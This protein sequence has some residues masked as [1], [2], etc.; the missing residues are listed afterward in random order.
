MPIKILRLLVALVLAL[1]IPLQGAASV[2]AGICMATGHHDAGAP[3]SHDHGADATSHDHGVDAAD[4]HSAPHD[5][6]SEAAHC[7]PCVACCAAA[8]IAPAAQVFLPE[9]SPAAAIAALP[10]LHPGFLPE[11]LDRPP[12]PL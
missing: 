1:A 8:S 12:L 7:A 10:Y 11:E 5:D 6:G 3:A 9:D 2:T 4:H